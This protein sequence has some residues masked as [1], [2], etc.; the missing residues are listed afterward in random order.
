[1]TRTSRAAFP[2]AILKDRQ[3][4]SGLSND[5][6]KGGAG[7]HNWGKLGEIEIDQNDFEYDSEGGLA[8]MSNRSTASDGAEQIPAPRQRSTSVPNEK[9]I[10]AAK[11]LRKNALNG[12]GKI[13]V[14]A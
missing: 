7:T 5:M 6:K 12:G 2:R 8:E 9:E 11:Q 3:S 4:R 10:Q 13:S 14:Y 1:M